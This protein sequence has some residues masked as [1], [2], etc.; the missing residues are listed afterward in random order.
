MRKMYT[1]SFSL[2]IFFAVNIKYIQKLIKDFKRISNK[3]IN[4]K[5]LACYV[6]SKI[7]ITN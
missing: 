6:V 5:I 7:K 1:D 3:T 4:L 2:K